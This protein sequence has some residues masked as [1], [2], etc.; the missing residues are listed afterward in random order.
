VFNRAVVSLIAIAA[1]AA[2]II[3]LLYGFDRIDV[4]QTLEIS[5][6]TTLVLIT[7]LYAMQTTI[8]AKETREQ[9]PFK[10]HWSQPK[11]AM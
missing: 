3:S 4:S 6:L 1:V 2:L 11:R 9:E 7:A 8:M 10:H 5:A